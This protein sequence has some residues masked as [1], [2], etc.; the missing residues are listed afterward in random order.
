MQKF[1]SS[2]AHGNLVCECFSGLTQFL[3]GCITARNRGLE[4]WAPTTVEYRA[5]AIRRAA[6]AVIFFN[7]P[8]EF[9]T[10]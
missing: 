4:V 6:F 1:V 5:T 9:E 7:I 3:G 8:G 10:V 2:H